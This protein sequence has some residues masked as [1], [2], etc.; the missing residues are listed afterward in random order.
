M[1][2][3]LGPTGVGVKALEL[4][5]RGTDLNAWGLFRKPPDGA[6]CS[7]A[8]GTFIRLL[9]EHRTPCFGGHAGRKG[10]SPK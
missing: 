1:Q 3:A 8:D 6:P 7:W 4:K 5:D 10:E 2:E 9:R